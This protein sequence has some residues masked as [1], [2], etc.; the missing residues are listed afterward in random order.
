[1]GEFVVLDASGTPADRGRLTVAKGKF[2]WAGW[3]V[4]PPPKPLRG[5]VYIR[6]LG[7]SASSQRRL[8]YPKLTLGSAEGII[9]TDT[10][11]AALLYRG[12][13]ENPGEGEYAVPAEVVAAALGGL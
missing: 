9:A 6:F 8:N 2:V 10:R 13:V 11:A 4:K 7:A 12:A 3:V 1:V 5:N